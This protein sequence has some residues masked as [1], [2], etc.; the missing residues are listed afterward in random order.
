MSGVTSGGQAAAAGV[1]VGW[2]VQA[3]NGNPVPNSAAMLELLQAARASGKVRR[4]ERARGKIGGG[5]G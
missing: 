4:R 2:V 5:L 3:V 1:Q